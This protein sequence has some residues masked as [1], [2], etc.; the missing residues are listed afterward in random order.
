MISTADG[1]HLFGERIGNGP[2]ALVI[3]Q[4]V[5]LFEYFQ[6]LAAGRTAIFYD[7]RNR[8]L[9]D[10]VT[11]PEKLS[12]GILHDVDDLDAI[13]RHYGLE[14]ISILAHS[15]IATAA[16]LYAAA[17]PER[18]KRVVLLGPMPPDP[19]KQYPPQLQYSDSTLETFQQRAADLRSQASAFSPEE[20][21]QKFWALLRTLY[22]ASPEKAHD[23]H[24]APCGIPNELN[25]MRPFLQ[26]VVP[27]LAAARPAAQALSRITAPVLIIHG[28][29]DRS[30]P[31]GG[32]RDWAASLPH[33]RILTVENAAHV[34]WI[35][36]PDTV[37]GAIETF[38]GGDWPVAAEQ[39]R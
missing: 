9:S 3:P 16:I 30:S 1:L 35:E 21:C 2:D 24:W 15:Y 10:T 6:R 14:R 25:F 31:Y 34:P 38:L 18:V 13:R 36:A 22:V 11:D 20:L 27:S 32:G 26:Y 5:Y 23:L 7:P 28:R 39:I 37:Y 8:G 17:H 12:R 29:Q 33:A 19:S 4:R